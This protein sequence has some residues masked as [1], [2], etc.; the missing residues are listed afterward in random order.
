MDVR[1]EIWP[2]AGFAAGGRSPEFSLM[3]LLDA[4][5]TQCLM[6]VD[7]V[8]RASLLTMMNGITRLLRARNQAE[9]P[10]D[11]EDYRLGVGIMLLDGRGKILVGKR[12]HLV[13]PTWQM[14][15]GGIE[16]G[17]A[18]DKAA[19]RE[20][21]EEIGTDNA[22]IIAQTPEWLYYDVPKSLQPPAW[23][24][25]WKGQRHKWFLMQFKGADSEINLETATPEF[26][27][28]CWVAPPAV[29]DLIAPF[30]RALY[31]RVFD[32]LGF[33]GNRQ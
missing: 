26:S 19:L 13:H 15:Q 16:P 5:E 12:R 11:P 2:D 10:R 31:V 32:H 18:P 24:G 25:R 22:D 4:P 1:Q 28:W 30:K 7:R 3:E 33:R 27:Q 20:L 23:G 29:L 6:A 21:K 14:P 8:D 17:E 9:A